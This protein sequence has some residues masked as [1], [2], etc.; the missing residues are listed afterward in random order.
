MSSAIALNI[1]TFLPFMRDA[2][3]TEASLRELS[4][5]WRLIEASAK[6]NCPS[7][8]QH[9]L[10]M[11]SV[12]RKGIQR[13]EH[14]LVAS[15]V[16]ETVFGVMAEI[17]TQAEHLI[18]IVVRNLYERTA[19]VGFLAMDRELCRYLESDASEEDRERITHRLREYR[20]KYTVYDDILLLTPDGLVVAQI[21]DEAPV[22]SSADPLLDATL[23]SDGFVETFRHSDL[24][25]GQPLALI[26]SRRITGESGQVLGVLCLSFGFTGE[27]AGIF[28]A[29]NGQDSRSIM[30]L[31]DGSDRVVATSDADWIP[32]GTQVPTNPSRAEQLYVHAGRA[33]LVATADPKGYQGY[34]GPAGW[35]GQVMT[36]VD[37]AFAAKDKRN[38]DGLDPA[39]AQGLLTHAQSFSPPLYEIVTAAETIR[40]VVW[41]G[42]VM[43]ASWD[44]ELQNL[45]LVLEQISETGVRTNQVFSRRIRDLYDTVLTASMR[46]G[47]FLTHLLVDLLD[48]NLYE[49]A[50]DCRWW[51]LTPEL[52]YL[53]AQPYLPADG[54]RQLES[55]L[56]S[57][58]RLYTV[59]SQLVVY[60]RFGVIV[61]A[62]RPH[63]AHGGNVVGTRIE[64]DTLAAVLSLRDSQSY[65]VTPFRPSP[66]YD[67]KPTYI[68]H[69]GIRAEGGAEAT[70]GGIGIVFHAERE[71]A[72]MLTGGMGEMPDTHALYVRRNGLVI[73]STDPRRPAGSTLDGFQELLALPRGEATSRVLVHD[74]CYTIVGCAASRGYREFKVSDGYSE[75]VLA[76]SF[77]TYG[78]K[79]PGAD[80]M[81]RRLGTLISEGSTVSGG[82][83]VATFYVNASLFGVPAE[84]VLQAL[85]ASALSRVTSGGLSHCVGAVP[86]M[87]GNKVKAY[88]WAFDL[89][90]LL[91]GK[92]TVVNYNSQVL[93]VR[94]QGR[95]FGL[96]VSDLQGVPAFPASAIMR[97]NNSPSGPRRLVNHVVQANEGKLLIQLL[98]S[99]CL[100]DVLLPSDAQDPG[101]SIVDTTTMAAEPA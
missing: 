61:A 98:D 14:E 76:L 48:R 50:D 28:D 66:L 27:M 42:Q 73:S 70:V 72:D 84:E 39:V 80:D 55:I 81:A 11:M 49:R 53:L 17:G 44:G 10:G 13:L 32:N 52:R 31:L 4:L 24:R 5:M 83:E 82:R 100:L 7:E 51:A 22:V 45:K 92:P 95:E 36:P 79:V 26:Y 3:R 78:A 87:Q 94:S 96:L 2:S 85:P 67:G 40:R 12:T 74:G 60:D 64:E 43:S 30:L 97:L 29:R 19:D 37:L 59:Y 93:L 8:S 65:H 77:R 101:R 58:H 25:P 33:Y 20:N 71:F 9:I 34:P 62:T 23:A 21:D 47:E 35:R 75:D 6:M 86:R 88:V 16:Q 68:Y 18:D 15:L 99:Q 1:D 69:A 63:F 38:I 89:G 56:E 46:E 41:N 90:Q 54:A 91:F 57:I